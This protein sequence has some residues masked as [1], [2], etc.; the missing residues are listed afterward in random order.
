MPKVD[1]DYPIIIGFRVPEKLKED[2]LEINKQYAIPAREAIEQYLPLKKLMLNPLALA[3][4][5]KAGNSNIEFSVSEEGF[6][7]M[8]INNQIIALDND[9]I[10]ILMAN[11]YLF[12]LNSVEA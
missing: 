7:Q 3:R 8:E 10:K 6:F 11:V 4:K 9:A 2:L 5:I 1:T 12:T